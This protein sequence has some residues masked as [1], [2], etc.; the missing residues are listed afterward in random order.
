MRV[1]VQA[2]TT[3]FNECYMTHRRLAKDLY[4]SVPGGLGE[5]NP[6]GVVLL[7]SGCH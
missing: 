6:L 3:V 1:Y 4:A 2:T 7:F 5:F